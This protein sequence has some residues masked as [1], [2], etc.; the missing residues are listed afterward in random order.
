M[1]AALLDKL[2]HDAEI[3][4]GLRMEEDECILS[5][6]EYTEGIVEALRELKAKRE[7]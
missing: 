7:T 2:L 1:D 3:E 6:T 5:L 4:A